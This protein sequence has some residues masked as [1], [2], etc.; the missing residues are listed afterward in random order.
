M[1]DMDVWVCP[2]CGTVFIEDSHMWVEPDRCPH[3]GAHY[4]DG[5]GSFEGGCDG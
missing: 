2:A 5:D 1:A 4:K 3:C